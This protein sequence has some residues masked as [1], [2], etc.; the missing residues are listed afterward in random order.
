MI[1][2]PV[3]QK[4]RAA[5]HDIDL[6]PGAPYWFDLE[7][8]DEKGDQLTLTVLFLKKPDGTFQ[9]RPIDIMIIRS[10]R[11]RGTPTVDALLDL[12]MFYQ[13]DVNRSIRDREF[14]NTEG[15][16]MSILLFNEKQPGEVED[17]NST[18][19]L[20]V[21]YFVDNVERE[22]DSNIMGILIIIVA[23]LLI[24][25]LLVLG[26]IFLK[27]KIKERSAFYN[28]DQSGYYVFRDIDDAVYYF[29]PAQYAK[30]Y[31]SNSL[32]TYEYLG[33]ASRKGGPIMNP[34]AQQPQALPMEAQPMTPVPIEDQPMAAGQAV[35]ED[36]YAKYQQ[37][38]DQTEAAGQPVHEIVSGQAAT[39]DDISR[40]GQDQTDEEASAS[41]ERDAV[42]EGEP[43]KERGPDNDPEGPPEPPYE[44]KVSGDRSTGEPI[45][46]SNDTDG[47]SVDGSV[48][49]QT[50]N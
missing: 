5:S 13:K 10:S 15:A 30:M 25:G 18:V 37:G 3:S 32:V 36:L 34:A 47:S 24:A 38:Q 14:K 12:A 31:A 6:G 29:T 41:D 7:D 22:G 2:Q 50:E 26:V 16:Q 48:E 17:Q 11:L 49:Q 23:A 28:T 35:P 9:E 21:D 27:K 43:E 39:V 40:K 1:S 4:A 42:P 45:T 20:R 44:E 33:Q 46:Q 19:R 8:F